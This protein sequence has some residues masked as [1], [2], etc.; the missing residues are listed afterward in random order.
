MLTKPEL[1]ILF[2][3]LVQKKKSQ[4]L[5]LIHLRGVFFFPE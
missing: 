2:R 5:K 3:N 1:H 4:V